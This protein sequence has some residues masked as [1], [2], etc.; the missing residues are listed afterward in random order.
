MLVAKS[1]GKK[2]TITEPSWPAITN[3]GYTSPGKHYV[4]QFNFKAECEE[5]FLNPE[6]YMEA[7]RKAKDLF[8]QGNIIIGA[9]FK[10]GHTVYTQG[11][12]VG[13]NQ[14]PT[15]VLQQPV[16]MHVAAP[17]TA[18]MQQ[19]VP[20]HAG[21]M[22]PQQVAQQQLQ[23]PNAASGSDFNSASAAL[24]RTLFNKCVADASPQDW[25]CVA[26][27]QKHQQLHNTEEQQVLTSSA[28]QQCDISPHQQ[29]YQHHHV[30]TS[31]LQLDGMPQHHQPVQH[32]QLCAPHS[33]VM[34]AGTQHHELQQYVQ[35]NAQPI[36]PLH[37]ATQ[38]QQL[39]SAHATQDQQ[40]LQHHPQVHGAPQHVSPQQWQHQHHQHQPHVPAAYQQC[41]ATPQESQLPAIPHHEAPQPWQQQQQQQHHQPSMQYMHHP[42]QVS[43]QQHVPETQHWHVPG[44]TQLPASHQQWTPATLMGHW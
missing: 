2:I 36:G 32:Q 16:P 43:D 21:V 7:V 11:T 9:E 24:L 4:M 17:P 25:A 19:P 38:N 31:H 14:A 41:T 6:T 20:M 34:Q 40:H 39:H 1:S 37:T 27:V 10:A 42:A 15:A 33:D 5:I 3:L 30:G 29:Q 18:V 12:P 8:D 26:A 22:P 28:Q 23:P 44:P 13:I 35:I